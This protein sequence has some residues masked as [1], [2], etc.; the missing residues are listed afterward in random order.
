MSSNVDIG[1]P[2]S[3]AGILM[4]QLQRRWRLTL[5]PSMPV[6]DEVKQLLRSQI[7]AVKFNYHLQTIE[8]SVEQNANNT[9]L[10]TLVKQFSKLSK[11]NKCDDINFVIEELDG[12]EEVHG[13]F[14]FNGCRLIDHNYELDYASS[15]VC[16]HTIKFSFKDTQDL[17]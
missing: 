11:L 8:M 17:T 5:L 16:R 3:G 6:I 12:M 13:R 9:Q 2:C 1:L 10:H 4:P 14:K 15:D 7:T